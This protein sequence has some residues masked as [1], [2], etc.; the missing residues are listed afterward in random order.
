MVNIRALYSLKDLRLP[1]VCQEAQK[2][3][4]DPTILKNSEL[5]RF[6]ME[7]E[8]ETLAIFWLW[9]LGAGR[10]NVGSVLSANCGPYFPEM[11]TLIEKLFDFYKATR[12]EATV[13]TS[14]EN[15][16]RMLKLLGFTR[17]G[18]MKKFYNGI[19]FDLYARVR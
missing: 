3:E 5:L 1:F 6:V 16:H 7:N 4:F 12:Y 11:K 18:T 19:D 17:E 2:D 15:G 13:K 8:K 10:Y 14:F 9:D